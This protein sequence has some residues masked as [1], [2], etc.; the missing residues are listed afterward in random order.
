MLVKYNLRRIAMKKCM[1]LLIAMTLAAGSAFAQEEEDGGIGLTAGLE[2]GVSG[3]NNEEEQTPYLTPGIVFERSF[4]NLDVYTELDYTL[5]FAD[6]VPQSLYA[7]EEIAYNLPLGNNTLT[8]TLNNQNDIVTAAPEPLKFGDA[9]E[10]GSILEPSVTYT[11]GL[12]P[13]DFYVTAGTPFTYQ[14]DTA[15]GAYGTLGFAFGFGLGLEAT[16]N[17]DITPEAGYGGTDFIV[18]YEHD[19]FYAE[20]E[21]NIDNEFKVFTITPEF[22][23]FFRNFTF[24]VNA[25]F[26]GVGDE[27]AISP[28]L[29]ITYSF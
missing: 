29:G 28:A 17:F 20:V 24:W 7:E 15:F 10:Y 14:A 3:I 23:Y 6:K 8:L 18:S 27:I 21:L 9:N 4:N 22:D 16:C 19:T 26:D 11:L 1:V 13:G 5:N 25:E 2:F 12:N